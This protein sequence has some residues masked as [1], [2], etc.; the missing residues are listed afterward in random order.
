MD[1]YGIPPCVVKPISHVRLLLKP[2]NELLFQIHFYRTTS[3][4]NSYH[5]ICF[6]KFQFIHQK[7]ADKL[8]RVIK[9]ERFFQAMLHAV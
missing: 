3:Y 7:I 1:W 4:V 5:F 9:F 6:C 8:H 2:S